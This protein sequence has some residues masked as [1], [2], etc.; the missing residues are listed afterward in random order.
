M[1]QIIVGVLI[2]I[3][4][5]YILKLILEPIIELKKLFGSISAFFLR[6]QHKITNASNAKIGQKSANATNTEY[7]LQ[8][9]DEARMLSSQLLSKSYAI[10]FYFFISTLFKLPCQSCILE[11]SQSLNSI[12]YSLSPYHKETEYS[13]PIT[14]SQ[15]MKRISKI[16][17]VP[18]SY[19]EL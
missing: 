16:L 17:N 3:I 19:S 5:Q 7:Y 6:E 2:F 12:G 14:I 9:H 18:L 8:L 4:G 15:D 13:N 10:P 1:S 11:V